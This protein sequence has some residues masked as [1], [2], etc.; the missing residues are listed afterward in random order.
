M[1]RILLL[2]VL[3]SSSLQAHVPGLEEI[4]C[5]AILDRDPVK[6]LIVDLAQSDLDRPME[7]AIQVVESG[8]FRMKEFEALAKL[9]SVDTRLVS[10]TADGGQA[11]LNFKIS[12]TGR[13]LLTM[14]VALES[15]YSEQGLKWI[16]PRVVE[17]ERTSETNEA[18][19]EP[20]A[21][22]ELVNEPIA[23]SQII[24]MSNW[25]LKRHYLDLIPPASN[26]LTLQRPFAL[27]AQRKKVGWVVVHGEYFLKTDLEDLIGQL[28]E[29][30]GAHISEKMITALAELRS[31][32]AEPNSFSNF[33]GSQG[34]NLLYELMERD[35]P[36]LAVPREEIGKMASEQ[37]RLVVIP[38][39][40]VKPTRTAGGQMES[41]EARVAPTPPRKPRYHLNFASN[42]NPILFGLMRSGLLSHLITG[43]PYH[44]PEDEDESIYLQVYG[45][46]QT[47]DNY[48]VR[49]QLAKL[50]NGDMEFEVLSLEPYSEVEQRAFWRDVADRYNIL[51]F[52][53]TFPNGH[54]VLIKGRYINEIFIAKQVRAKLMAKHDLTDQEINRAL[55][56]LRQVVP[57][58]KL[59]NRYK[60]DVVIDGQT[61][62][63]GL[64]T[65]GDDDSVYLAT[66]YRVN[67]R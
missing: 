32:D 54:R 10:V 58:T 46:P 25:A 63:V 7:R 50:P 38:I 31:T 4:L 2:F 39:A 16:R 34:F 43:L 48:L 61:Y 55:S 23:P 36:Y 5:E 27:I 26:A 11:L 49:Y 12:G 13:Q 44:L 3:F 18:P 67:G 28:G 52:T 33:T 51:D 19:P 14:I 29:K 24:T 41:G 21:P 42:V 45:N 37:H 40:Q 56:A 9:H 62:R 65:N 60:G 64:A 66:L 53:F 22:V 57:V 6:A 15:Q 1:K 59:P 17:A 20:P 8:T 30:F 35:E 47:R